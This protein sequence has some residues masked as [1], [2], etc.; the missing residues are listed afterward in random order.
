MKNIQKKYKLVIAVFTGLILFQTSLITAAAIK[1]KAEKGVQIPGEAAPTTI[2]TTLINNTENYSL[3]LRTDSEEIKNTGIKAIFTAVSNNDY[4]PFG[5]KWI[6]PGAAPSVESE[7][8]NP[9]I[10]IKVAYIYYTKD[11]NQSMSSAP[12]MTIQLTGETGSQKFSEGL[13][14]ETKVELVHLLYD[15]TIGGD[16]I[17]R[18][19]FQYTFIVTEDKNIKSK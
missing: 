1:S 9:R 14:V 7:R 5:E 13:T 4:Y 16:P 11:I 17:F 6:K 3:G 12:Y 2:K 19:F 10:P 15:F 18:D 8:D